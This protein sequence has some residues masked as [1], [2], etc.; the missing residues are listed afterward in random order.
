MI[1]PIG[2]EIKNIRFSGHQLTLDGTHLPAGAYWLRIMDEKGRV[3]CK[4]IMVE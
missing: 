2:R 1:D 4:K 3:T